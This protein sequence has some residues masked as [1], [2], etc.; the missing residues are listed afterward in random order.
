ML[1]ILACPFLFKKE[2]RFEMP[3]QSV[4][5]VRVVC[6]AAL[7]IFIL[8]AYLKTAP[9]VLYSSLEAEQLTCQTDLLKDSSW[10]GQEIEPD[11]TAIPRMAGPCF[12][13]ESDA[14]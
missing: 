12:L 5:A 10:I 4:L 7:T 3:E 13:T 9:P 1:L 2:K 11:E 14:R 8:Y 6:M